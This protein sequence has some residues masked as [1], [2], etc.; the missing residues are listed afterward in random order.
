MS[1]GSSTAKGKALAEGNYDRYS[2]S[3]SKAIQLAPDALFEPC[4][5]PS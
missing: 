2:R 1:K 5:A 4:G 3:Y